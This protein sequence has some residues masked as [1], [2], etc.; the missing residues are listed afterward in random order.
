MDLQDQV[1]KRD[2]PLSKWYESVASVEGKKKLLK[3]NDAIAMV[4]HCLQAGVPPEIKAAESIKSMDRAKALKEQGT[5]LFKEGDMRG[6][7]DAYTESLKY[8]PLKEDDPESCKEYSVILANRSATLDAG[9]MYEACIQ[10]IDYAFKY[11]YPKHLQFKV[12]INFYLLPQGA[13]CN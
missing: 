10:D 12:T 5:L 7:R 9:R 1:I 2:S 3:L 4:N 13:Y 6:A 11:G 8:F